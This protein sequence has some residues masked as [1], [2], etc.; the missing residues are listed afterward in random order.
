MLNLNKN[1]IK[2]LSTHPVVGMEPLWILPQIFI[3]SMKFTMDEDAKN[4]LN[5]TNGETY[6]S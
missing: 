2:L 5:P 4:T 1:V 6:S 3:K